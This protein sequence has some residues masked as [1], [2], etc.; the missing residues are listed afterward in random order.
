MSFPPK[1]TTPY[2][3]G[4]QLVDGTDVNNIFDAYQSSQTMSPAGAV[5][6]AGATVINAALVEILAGAAASAVL[7]PI[8]YPGAEVLILNNSSNSQ[9]V[10]GTG[11]DVVQ[12]DTTTYAAAATGVS[13]ASLRSAIYRCIKTGF[14]QVIKTN[15]T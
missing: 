5:S 8:S 10:F 12:F 13:L 4:R 7:L 14:W 6:Q 11:A 15:G 1:R 3:P 9:Q 2:N